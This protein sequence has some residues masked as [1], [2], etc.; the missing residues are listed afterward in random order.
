MGY[1]LPSFGK[2][3]IQTKQTN[4]QNL[5]GNSNLFLSE[6]FS[7]LE[8]SFVSSYHHHHRYFCCIEEAEELVV[9]IKR[10]A[11]FTN[12]HEKSIQKSSQGMYLSC[13]MFFCRQSTAYCYYYILLLSIKKETF[14]LQ[15][16][17]K[18]Y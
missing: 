15:S 5:A 9:V 3:S 12:H 11:V 6:I 1:P 10:V 17:L 13:K 16:P 2:A 7:S 14:T 4:K 18:M 8:V